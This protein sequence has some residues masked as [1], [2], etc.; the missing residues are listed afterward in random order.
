MKC[1]NW[2]AYFCHDHRLPTS[3]DSTKAVT[4]LAVLSFPCQI[5]F[6]SPSRPS[7]SQ[8]PD[9]RAIVIPFCILLYPKWPSLVLCTF[10]IFLNSNSFLLL[11]WFYFYRN[12]FW[13]TLITRSTLTWSTRLEN[14]IV[15]MFG[16]IQNK[17][18]LAFSFQNLTHFGSHE[19]SMWNTS[20]SCLIL[21]FLFL[22]VQTCL[23][24]SNST[25]TMPQ[26]SSSIPAINCAFSRSARPKGEKSQTMSVS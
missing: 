26:S 5:S 22:F 12:F 2:L 1:L 14:I 4:K 8:A 25:L 19:W 20:M 15:S 10:F 17:Y 3:T 24:L 13:P 7:L 18:T 23:N 11:P 9:L 16:S 6:L 21:I